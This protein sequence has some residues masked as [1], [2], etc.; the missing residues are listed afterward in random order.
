MNQRFLPCIALVAGAFLGGCASGPK[1]SEVSKSIAPIPAGDGRLYFF[2]SSSMIGAGVQPDIRVDGQVVGS[3][4]PGGFFYVDEPAGSHTAATSTEVEKSTT[5]TLAAGETKYLRTAISAGLL[6]GHVDVTIEDP[7]KAQAEI[8]TLSLSGG[9]PASPARAAAKAAAP[10]ESPA[11]DPP[12]DASGR[13]VH[14]RHL[15]AAALE[16]RTWTFPHPRDPA[17]YHDVRI[18]FANG[19]ANATNAKSASSGPYT[20]KD[21][22]VCVEF[23]TGDWGRACYYLYDN[24]GDATPRL[25]TVITHH[26][27]PVTID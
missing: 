14:A 23:Q 21:D 16:G 8:E 25:L 3:S 2:R 19:T 4:K 15:D 26:N 5:F 20:V 22:M 27:V 7:Q 24:P 13:P 1:Y 10:S 9:A 12:T 6:V 18:S 17:R 11:V